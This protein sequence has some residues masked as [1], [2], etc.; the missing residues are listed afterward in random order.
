MRQT[1]ADLIDEVY[2]LVEDNNYLRRTI[3]GLKI[4]IK[5]L[6]D[7]IAIYKNMYRFNEIG[8]EAIKVTCDALAHVISNL[9]QR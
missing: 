7:Q 4:D 8:S 1:K 3:D 5:A 9:K 2:A 6:N